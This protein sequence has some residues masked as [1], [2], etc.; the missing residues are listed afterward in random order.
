M[1][2]EVA[3][4]ADSAAADVATR[5]P[6]IKGNIVA[7]EGTEV[8]TSR[9]Q[10]PREGIVAFHRTATIAIVL[11]TSAGTAIAYSTTTTASSAGTEGWG[12]PSWEASPG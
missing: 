12:L 8:G 5:E 2:I 6:T 9:R 11:R 7:A 10:L 1:L 4:A 3:V